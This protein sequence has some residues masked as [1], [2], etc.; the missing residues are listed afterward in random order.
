M[1]TGSLFSKVINSAM[2]Y[3]NQSEITREEINR[4]KDE[5]LSEKRRIQEKQIRALRRNYRFST[6]LLGNSQTNQSGI[7]N[8]LGE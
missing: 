1:N 4:K 7:N 2:D 5:Q 3:Y 8:K 6:P